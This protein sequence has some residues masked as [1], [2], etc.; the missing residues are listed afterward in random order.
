MCFRT[1][2]AFRAVSGISTPGQATELSGSA[3]TE[4]NLL[5]ASSLGA[6]PAIWK[7]GIGVGAIRAERGITL[8]ISASEPTLIQFDYPRHRRIFGFEQNY[9]R[10]N[11]FPEWFTVDES[12]RYQLRQGHTTIEHFGAELIGGIALAP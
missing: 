1:T 12:A 6:R 11:E 3:I 4:M 2:M 8:Q 5:S 10:L 7:P 9:A